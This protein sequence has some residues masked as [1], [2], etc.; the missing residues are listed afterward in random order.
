MTSVS[1]YPDRIPSILEGIDLVGLVERYTGQPGGR[2]GTRLRWACPHPDHADTDPSFVVYPRKRPPDFYC[3]GCGWGGDAITFLTGVEGLSR[4]EVIDR[5]AG[6]LNLGEHPR[7]ESARPDPNR[8]KPAR[9]PTYT[10]NE[11][12]AYVQACHTALTAPGILEHIAALGVLANG[13]PDA[14][15]VSAPPAVTAWSYLLERGI[16]LSE[17][18]RHRI[19][20]GI[21]GH[22]RFRTLRARLILPCPDGAEAR[23]IPSHTENVWQPEQRYVVPPGDPKHPWGIDRI[24][25]ARGPLMIVEGI[26]DALALQRAH[27]QTVALRGKRLRPGDAAAICTAGFA[28]VLVGL[29]SDASCD[30]IRTLIRTLAAAGV[31]AR[32]ARGPENGD[33]GDLLR[34]PDHQL[35]QAVAAGTVTT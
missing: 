21:T 33:W 25:P 19:G 3:Y 26:F 15:V 18:H 27:V 29:D 16:T 28:T 12:G 34:L 30:D 17:V 9:R 5:L 32:V 1:T 20:H 31:T 35:A 2:D 24:N 23:L 14:V 8:E 4:A 13:F 11:L 7:P 6:E 10:A 22:P